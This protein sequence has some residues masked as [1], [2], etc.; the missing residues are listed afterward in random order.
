M[1]PHCQ[2]HL[3]RAVLALAS[4]QPLL[5]AVASPASLLLQPFSGFLQRHHTQQQQH[6]SCV[7][8]HVHHTG[9]QQQQHYEELPATPESAQSQL[10][11][12]WRHLEQLH[13]HRLSA[14]TCSSSSLWPAQTDSLCSHNRSASKC[15]VTV[16]PGSSNVLRLATPHFSQLPGSCN[17]WLQHT[18]GF[19]SQSISSSGGADSTS[20][21]KTS[22]TTTTT[23]NSGSTSTSSSASAD[24]W[25]VRYLPAGCVPY[26]HLMRL[27]KPIGSWLLA[28]PGL[29]C[30][31]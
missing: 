2:L 18:A 20:S 7:H 13:R 24:S 25:V 21:T 1:S 9:R 14:H 17:S 28:W 4:T 26:A 3:S 30:V 22:N 12:Q 29:W 16:A 23:S 19:S 10:S 5:A 15:A 27:D 8:Q 6:T 11:T 31:V